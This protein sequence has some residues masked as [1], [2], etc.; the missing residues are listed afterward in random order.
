MSHKGLR[1]DILNALKR[2]APLTARDLT[3]Q[4]ADP[5]TPLGSQN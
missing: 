3:T 2:E 4:G 5:G 1:G